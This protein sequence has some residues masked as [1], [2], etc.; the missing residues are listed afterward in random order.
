MTPLVRLE[1]RV[2]AR[3]WSVTG[4]CSCWQTSWPSTRFQIHKCPRRSRH[5]RLEDAS[6]SQTS[7][8]C[9]KRIRIYSTTWASRLSMCYNF[10]W[11]AT[12]ST[13]VSLLQTESN[14]TP[15]LS[16]RWRS[17]FNLLELLAS[18]CTRYCLTRSK[19]VRQ[20]LTLVFRFRTKRSKMKSLP[21]RK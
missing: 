15:K 20:T 9:G 12:R 14:P 8:F 21:S 17:N 1:W 13:S 11:T 3:L 16:R 7:A 4:Y 18:S 10:S 5:N 19:R 6:T 2:Y